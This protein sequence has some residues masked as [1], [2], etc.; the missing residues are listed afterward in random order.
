[1]NTQ[2]W[3][4]LGWTGWSWVFIGRTDAEAE[5]P[6]LWPPRAKSWL[7]GKDPNAGRD[8]G[9]EEKGMTEDEM[10]GW[11]YRLDEHEF[12]WALGVGDGQGGL[13]C[14]DSWGR[15]E[16][17]TT[18]RLNW[19]L[20]ISRSIHGAAMALFRSFYGWVIFHCIY[21]PH[22]LYPSLCFHV[23]AIVNSAAMNIGVHV[24]FQI[25]VFSRYM[26]RNGIA[27]SYHSSIF[28]FLRNFHTVLHSGCTNLHSHQQC[29]RVPFSPHPLQNL[30]F[31]DF[32]W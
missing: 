14:C 9:Q 11:H 4:P 13:A 29:R 23:L 6:I 19:S 28:S 1:M 21:V 3:S 20:T 7:I 22:L 17:D 30:L 8:W 5:T 12:E 26:P 24:S 18:E 2:D 10:A 16:S 25:K 31:V 15:K 32:L 27:P